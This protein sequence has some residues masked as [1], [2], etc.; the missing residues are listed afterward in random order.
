MIMESSANTAV[1]DINRRILQA[2]YTFIS[3]LKAI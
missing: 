2:Q 3:A 1:M